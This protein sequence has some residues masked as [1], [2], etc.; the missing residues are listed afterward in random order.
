MA[1]IQISIY[2][3]R[4]STNTIRDKARIKYHPTK[5]EPKHQKH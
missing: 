2:R 5:G 4:I 3:I 1:E